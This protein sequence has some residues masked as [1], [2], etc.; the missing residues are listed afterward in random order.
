VE[1]LLSS[2]AHTAMPAS[3]DRLMPVRLWLYGIAL[4]VL[5]MVVV[6]GATRLTDSGLSITEWKPISG[7]IPPLSD[8]DWQA[9]FSAY[10]QIP[11]YSLVNHTM[12][13][14]EFKGIFWWEWAHRAL[15][16]VIGFAFFV[17][18]VVFLWQRRLDWKLAPALAVLFVLGGLQG[19]LGWWMV[20]SGLSER[21]DVSQYRLAAHLSA[22]CALYLALLFVARRIRPAGERHVEGRGWVWAVAGFGAL[23]FLQIVAGAFVAGLDAGFVHNDW[24]LMTGQWIPFDLFARSPWWINFFENL[25]T[26]QFAHRIIAYLILFCALW[27]ALSSF[28]LTGWGGVQGWAPV[29]VV[30]T[31]IQAALGIV[32]LMLV[33]PLGLALAHQLVAFLLIGAVVLWLEDLT[34]PAKV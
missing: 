15:G 34:H 14:E 3:A 31:L 18:F 29:V 16:R 17:P 7:I 6:G 30:L 4:L 11:E 2:A 27:L 8:A 19:A 25:T 33:V 24:P 10:Q 9:E 21:I 5:L 1:R 26:V 20:T 12:S 28:R 22:A 23:I 13:L 32:T